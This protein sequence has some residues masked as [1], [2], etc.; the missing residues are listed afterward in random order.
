[1]I[2]MLQINYDASRDVIIISAH[3][4]E[5]FMGEDFFFHPFLND[6]QLP[7]RLYCSCQV[8][9]YRYVFLK[10]NNL[11][12]QLLSLT[13]GKPGPLR[14]DCLLHLEKILNF[15]GLLF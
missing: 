9:R 14:A 11:P 7:D 13:T 15:L 3:G 4:F 8:K 1:M 12:P 5:R 10:I 2:Y 6:K